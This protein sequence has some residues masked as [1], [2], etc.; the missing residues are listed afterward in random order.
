MARIPENVYKALQD[1]DTPAV[2]TTVDPNGNPN[3][4]YVMLVKVDNPEIVLLNDSVF[5]KTRANILTGSRGSVVF[6]T[7]DHKAY[8]IKG[9]LKYHT[10]G[11]LFDHMRSVVEEIH[12]RVAAVE[13]IADEVYEGADKLL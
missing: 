13:L 5:T 12:A 7:A 2:F 9:N 6:L 8:Q 1:L 3:A 10:S 4:A 11:P